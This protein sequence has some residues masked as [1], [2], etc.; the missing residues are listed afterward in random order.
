LQRGSVMRH[1]LP[2]LVAV[3]V[4]VGGREHSEYQP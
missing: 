3:S 4:L 1:A 2:I